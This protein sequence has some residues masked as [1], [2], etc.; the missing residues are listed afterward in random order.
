MRSLLAGVTL[1]LI[2]VSAWGAS[3]GGSENYDVT[4]VSEQ[5]AIQPGRPF[6]V[7]LRME[8]E[9]GWHT[10]WK[11]P[12]DAGLPLKIEWTLPPG[13]T[14]GPIEWP[15]PVRFET[16]PIVSYGYDREVLLAVPI[17]PPERIAAKSVTITGKFDWLECAEVCVPGSAT[18]ELRMPVHEGEPARSPAARHFAA[19]RTNRPAAPSGWDLSA[20]AGPRAVSLTIRPP[21]GTSARSGYFF[22]DQPLVADYAGAQGFERVGDRYRLTVPPAPSRTGFPERLTGALVLEGARTQGAR[23]AVEVDV[24]LSAGDP[25]PAAEAPTLAGGASSHASA[26]SAPAPNAPGKSG[27][28]VGVVAGAVA[29]GGVGLILFRRRQRRSASKKSSP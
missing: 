29:L 11:N 24:L 20:E 16:G 22:A 13:F 18:L 15:T 17:T 28:P 3:T 8:P 25:A 23:A 1:L 6:Y 10:Y 12:G 21:K 9:P 5:A 7:G 27:V 19:A 26:D 14:A 2:A 4:L